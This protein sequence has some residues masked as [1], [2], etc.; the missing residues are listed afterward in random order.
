MNTFERIAKKVK[1]IA[2][3]IEKIDNIDLSKSLNDSRIDI[4]EIE[5]EILELINE[6]IATNQS[7]DNKLKN[8]YALASELNSSA[9]YVESKIE[10][11]IDN[12][13]KK[14]IEDVKVCR[15]IRDTILKTIK[16]LD[17]YYKI[18]LNPKF[19]FHGVTHV[20]LNN[21]MNELKQTWKNLNK[22]ITVFEKY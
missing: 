21:K 3:E 20:M 14:T 8:L 18:H 22:T 7:I 6:K 10:T 16:K 1:R 11:I 17:D 13:K 5:K 9:F 2:N 12:N 15:E 19:N 4:L